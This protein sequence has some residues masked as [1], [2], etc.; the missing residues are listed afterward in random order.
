M[1]TVL[2]ISA[3]N[4]PDIF[5][6]HITTPQDLSALFTG[7][8]QKSPELKQD[9]QDNMPKYISYA[10]SVVKNKDVMNE[11]SKKEQKILTI[12]S[13]SRNHTA[14]YFQ[15]DL[16]KQDEEVSQILRNSPDNIKN[17]IASYLTKNE[18]S[19]FIL[20]AVYKQNTTKAKQTTFVEKL[21]EH[22]AEIA[23]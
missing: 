14:S 2:R 20:E 18:S 8:S 5:K 13:D 15:R 6:D 21:K 9:F 23:R 7:I 19:P 10:S 1:D 4:N 3:N 11:L 22:A 12:V 17:E 16:E